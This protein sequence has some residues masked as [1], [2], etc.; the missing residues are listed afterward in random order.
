LDDAILQDVVDGHPLVVVVQVDE[1]HD[2]AG[3][4]TKLKK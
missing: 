3:Y 1:K 4:F 2:V